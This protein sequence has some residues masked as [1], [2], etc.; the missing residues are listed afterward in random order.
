MRRPYRLDVR[1]AVVVTV[2]SALTLLGAGTILSLEFLRGQFAIEERGLSA[3][4][5][6]WAGLL[7]RAPDGT[8]VFDRPADP[9]EELDPP[10]TGLLSGT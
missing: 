1:L 7:R 5:E 3:Q 4:V 8:V 2:I 6:E 9:S 10:Y